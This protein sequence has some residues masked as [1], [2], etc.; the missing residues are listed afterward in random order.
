MVDLFIRGKSPFYQFGI[1]LLSVSG[2]S[3]FLDRE[4]GIFGKLSFGFGKL[5]SGFRDQNPPG[6]MYC[7]IWNNILT[8]Y[9]TTLQQD[10][11]I[12]NG[13]AHPHF[14]GNIVYHILETILLNSWVL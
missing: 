13:I 7:L 5:S 11:E 3:M 6:I 9:T 4:F 2:I 8:A 12:S 1:I 14:Y 10:L